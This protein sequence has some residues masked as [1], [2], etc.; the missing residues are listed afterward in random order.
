MFD[1]R[2]IGPLTNDLQALKKEA[3][4]IASRWDGTSEKY[5]DDALLA[6]D[7][8]DAIEHLTNLIEDTKF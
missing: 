1:E 7:I 6:R 8:A 3:D 2:V 5:E 4:N